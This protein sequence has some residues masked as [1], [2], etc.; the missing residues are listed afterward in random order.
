MR[1]QRATGLRTLSQ[2]SGRPL[3]L[4]C[5]SGRASP[6]LTA[7][8]LHECPRAPPNPSPSRHLGARDRDQNFTERLPAGTAA[9]EI[10]S[11]QPTSHPPQRAHASSGP[12]KRSSWSSFCLYD[13]SIG[14]E[15]SAAKGWES[16]PWGGAI[17]D[18][19]HE[20]KDRACKT[21]SCFAHTRKSWRRTGPAAHHG[22]LA[23]PHCASIEEQERICHRLRGV[24]SSDDGILVSTRVSR[25]KFVATGRIHSTLRDR[26]PFCDG[27]CSAQKTG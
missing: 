18:G 13:N 14:T 25:G 11:G 24:S 8:A 7:Q 19:Q 21:V 17:E 6:Y 23:E 2:V 5:L 26:P 27:Y 4:S 22:D 15:K 16:V 12:P 10:S 9:D 1:R 20:R 3:A